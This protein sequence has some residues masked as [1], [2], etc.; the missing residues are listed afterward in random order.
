MNEES[1][2]ELD[3]LEEKLKR[4]E[5]ASR[6]EEMPVSGKSVFNIQRIKEKRSKQ[7]K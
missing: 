7:D 4:E 5:Q 6:K 3:E 1:K 2:Q